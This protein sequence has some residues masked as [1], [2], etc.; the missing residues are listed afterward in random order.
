MC[1][2]QPEEE[3]VFKASDER[4]A[5]HRSP[6]EGHVRQEVRGIKERSHSHF[7]VSST[8]QA[9]RQTP[10]TPRKLGQVWRTRPSAAGGLSAR[11]GSRPDLSRTARRSTESGGWHI[12]SRCATR[13]PWFCQHHSVTVNVCTYTRPVG[14]PAHLL[15]LPSLELLLALSLLGLATRTSGVLL[16]GFFGSHHLQC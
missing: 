10:S 4:G 11:S 7:S 15:L 3:W 13:V 14:G 2:P 12:V 9:P 16:V 5:F 6:N 8:A 1:R